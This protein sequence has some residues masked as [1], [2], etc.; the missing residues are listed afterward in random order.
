MITNLSQFTQVIDINTIIKRARYERVEIHKTKKQPRNPLNAQ[1]KIFLRSQ[2]F[3]HCISFYLTRFKTF[4][5]E[6]ETQ[7]DLKSEAILGFEEMLSKFD[8]SKMT[9]NCPLEKAFVGTWCETINF[10]VKK[11]IDKTTKQKKSI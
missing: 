5:N 11:T 4:V 6:D 10:H 9:N 1:E 2:S 3:H 8:K 7:E